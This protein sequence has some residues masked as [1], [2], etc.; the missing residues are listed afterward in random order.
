MSDTTKLID[1]I[2]SSLADIAER[3]DPRSGQYVLAAVDSVLAEAV[4]A[5]SKRPGIDVKPLVDALRSIKP[6]VVVNVP[7]VQVLPM[8][9]ENGTTWEIRQAGS[10]GNP[11]RVL[12]VKRV[13]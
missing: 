5:L 11:D 7:P 6:S 13:A 9:Q 3:L 2:E 10:F 1:S 8:M 12:T 4:E